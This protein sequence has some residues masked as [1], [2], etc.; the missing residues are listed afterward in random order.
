MP[1]IIALA[2]IAVGIAVIITGL[3]IAG[4]ILERRRRYGKKEND[5]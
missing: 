2:V 5:V 1:I 4:G 3:I